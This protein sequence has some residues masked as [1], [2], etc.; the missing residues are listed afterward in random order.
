MQDTVAV[1]AA[2]ED[3]D[4]A[5]ALVAQAPVLAQPTAVLAAG[6][7]SG[8]QDHASEKGACC[9]EFQI[10]RIV[11]TSEAA[12]LAIFPFLPGISKKRRICFASTICP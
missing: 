12:S 2:E 11:R 3:V 4:S 9:S 6:H 5:A 10:S 8:H 1:T 7:A